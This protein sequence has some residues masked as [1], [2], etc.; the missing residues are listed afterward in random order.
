MSPSWAEGVRGF[1]SGQ[2]FFFLI[3]KRAPTAAG[4]PPTAVGY[5]ATAVGYPATAVGYPPT[6]VGYPSTAVWLTTGHS[7]FFFL[8]L[9]N[10]LE[11]VQVVY[12]PEG[13]SP[14]KVH[15]PR[16]CPRWD[17]VDVGLE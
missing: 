14:V 7:S 15:V 9:K 12:R 11:G 1:F 3:K 5:P 6:A 17:F 2:D 8:R 10:L 13:R 16:S 4:C